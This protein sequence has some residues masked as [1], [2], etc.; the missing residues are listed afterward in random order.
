MKPSQWIGV[1]IAVLLVLGLAWW[2]GDDY[3]DEAR[4][5]LRALLRAL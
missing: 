5:A 1:A 4:T 2:L 3:R